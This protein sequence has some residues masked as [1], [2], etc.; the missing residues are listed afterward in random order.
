MKFRKDLSLAGVLHLLPLRQA[1]NFAR[2]IPISNAINSLYYLLI[3]DAYEG[4][5]CRPGYLPIDFLNL[6][7]M[8]TVGNRHSPALFLRLNRAVRSAQFM[9]AYFSVSTR[10]GE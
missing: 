3:G 7:C 5:K 2:Y 10:T 6:S 1:T 8:K 4:A 9:P